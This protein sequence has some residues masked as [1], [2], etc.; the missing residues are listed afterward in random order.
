MSAG[1]TIVDNA[2]FDTWIAKDPKYLLTWMEFIR[3]EKKGIVKISV[4]AN[5]LLTRQRIRTFL[6]KLVRDGYV[7]IL[8]A[9]NNGTTLRLLPSEI[10]YTKYSKQ[11]KP[12]QTTRPRGNVPTP[13]NEQ[14]KQ[15]QI[16][17]F[18]KNKL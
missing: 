9:D 17:K 13:T 1:F 3:N 10:F 15:K 12:K 16:D 2:V 14:N 8:R 4:R 11:G 6:T 7:E 18:N 5:D